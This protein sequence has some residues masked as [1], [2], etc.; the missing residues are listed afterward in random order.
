MTPFDLGSLEVR[1]AAVPVLQGVA[2]GLAGTGTAGLTWSRSG[3]LVYAFGASTNDVVTLQHQ[4]GTDPARPFDP[5]WKGRF[6]SFALS[7]DGRRAA[8]GISAGGAGFDVWIKQLDNGPLTRLTFSGR[9]RRPTWSPDGRQVAFV[10]DSTSGGDVYVRAVDGSGSDR[11][12][13]HID[14]AIQEVTWSRDGR[15]L[16]VRTETGAAGS[17]DIVA[18]SATGDS[19]VVNI[20]TGPFT[21]MQPALSPDGRWVAY[22]SNEAGA[23]QVYVRPF[24]NAEASRWQV[25]NGGGGSPAWSANGRELFFLDPANRLVAAQVTPGATFE[26]TGLTPLFDATPF[27]YAGYHQAFEVTKDGRFVFL[28]PVG[29][30]ATEAPKLV[31][32][33]NWFADIRARLK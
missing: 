33:D 28:G 22:V 24:P 1:G 11:R 32:I 12:L 31:Q 14:R 29:E 13:A 30:V 7:P 16:V 25:S 3:R 20:A 10:R 15:W 18:L 4:G 9:D 5:S 8:V 27:S 17:G 19:A 2:I 26:V 21:E 6:N 23:Y